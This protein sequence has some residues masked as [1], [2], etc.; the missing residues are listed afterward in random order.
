MR[1]GGGRGIGN[2]LNRLVHR[3][4]PRFVW[5]DSG[6]NIFGPIHQIGPKLWST[7]SQIGQFGPIFKTMVFIVIYFRFDRFLM[8][9]RIIYVNL[10]RSKDME[11]S[12]LRF[13]IVRHLLSTSTF[14]KLQ[15]SEGSTILEASTKLPILYT[16]ISTLMGSIRFFQVSLDLKLW[17]H[18]TSL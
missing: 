8:K 18:R 13:P 16:W 6:S 7:D 17:M 10:R 4:D 2:W 9:P 1:G 5:F 15:P 14:L 12:N 3:S 11:Q